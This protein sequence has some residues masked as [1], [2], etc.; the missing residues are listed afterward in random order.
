LFEAL[1]IVGALI[2]IICMYDIEFVKKYSMFILLSYLL[3]ANFF[4]FFFVSRILSRTEK[5]LNRTDITIASIFGN[6]VS[7]VFE[8]G[9]IVILVYNESDEVIWVSQTTL[10]KKDDLLGQKIYDLI[11]D[12]NGK[13]QRV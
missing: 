5:Y 13:L 12:F 9:D 2:T 11:A 3:I 1:I 10:V 6:E 8:F 7:P 4:N